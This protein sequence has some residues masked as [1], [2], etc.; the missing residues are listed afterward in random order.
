MTNPAGASRRVGRHLMVC[1]VTLLL[2]A[3]GVANENLNVR[4]PVAVERDVATLAVHGDG[5]QLSEADEA[6]LGAFFRHYRTRGHGELTLSVPGGRID[7][8]TAVARGASLVAI[9]ADNG[10]R[11]ADIDVRLEDMGNNADPVLMTFDTYVAVP[12]ECG[13]WSKASQWTPRNTVH[14][15]FGCTMQRN[16][17]QALADPA[18]I[19]R[20]RT[21]STRDATR[22]D[23][24]VQQYRAGETTLSERDA[25]ESAEIVQIE[26]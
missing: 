23:L 15:N 6:Q 20:S 22:S 8:E 12:P 9:A 14:S 1:G 16:F 4:H 19:V 21:A 3:C 7:A 25:V 26:E 11:P 13:D 18:D 2:A 24:V 10:V 17:A 5:S